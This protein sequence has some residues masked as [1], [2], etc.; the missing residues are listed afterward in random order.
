LCTHLILSF[1]IIVL[2]EV[3]RELIVRCKGIQLALLFLPSSLTEAPA[4]C[5]GSVRL[6]PSRVATTMSVERPFR[7]KLKTRHST[8]TN[9][10]NRRLAVIQRV[11][12][13]LIAPVVVTDPK[14]NVLA[15]AVAVSW[16]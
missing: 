15:V 8:W 14:I 13:P 1:R 6:H 16:R 4:H 12:F 5:V 10:L 11:S 3:I 7:K 9:L 2:R